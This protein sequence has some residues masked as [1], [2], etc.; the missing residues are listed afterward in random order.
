ME[1]RVAREA[2]SNLFIAIL[3]VAG[4]STMHHPPG[5]RQRFHYIAAPR[6]HYDAHNMA[7]PWTHRVS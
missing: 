3:K 4:T 2:R 1:T 6:L 7:L 5:K